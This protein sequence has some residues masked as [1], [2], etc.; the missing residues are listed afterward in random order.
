[1]LLHDK[2]HSA[3][4]P[5]ITINLFHLDKKKKQNT[6]SVSVSEYVTLKIAVPTLGHVSLSQLC[7]NNT[8]NEKTIL[9]IIVNERK[10]YKRNAS[11]KPK[12]L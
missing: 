12:L 6:T 10:Y 1:M 7:R 4:I 8:K 9:V 3:L 2:L 5:I 11:F